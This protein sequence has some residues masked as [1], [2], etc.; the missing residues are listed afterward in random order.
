MFG[1]QFLL[2][3][4]D[5]DRTDFFLIFGANPV[6]SQ[7]SAMT[8]PGMKS[9]LKALRARGGR[10]VVVDPRRT[11]T[12]ALADTHLFIRPGT[13]GLLVAAMLRRVLDRECPTDLAPL[14][15]A[16]APFT[17]EAVARPTGVDAATINAL[18]DDFA[19]AEHAVAYG[20][21]GVSV[22]EFGTTTTWLIEALNHATGNLDAIGGAMFGRPAV[23]LAG[24]ARYS[25]QQGGFGPETEAGL[26]VFAGERPVSGLAG[27]IESGA[28]R[29]FVTQAGNP[30]LS[31]PG[32]RR[33]DAAFKK[34]EYFVAFDPRINETTR[35]AHLI[36]PPPR[37]L[38]RDWYG[39][40]FNALALRDVARYNPPV[41]EPDAHR[42]DCFELLTGVTLAALRHR[43]AS[44]LPARA[45]V[46]TARRLGPRRM[47]DLLLRLGPHRLSLT[48]LAAAPRGLDLGAR[49]AG[50][51]RKP[52]AMCHPRLMADLD[53]L[54][55]SLAAEPPPLVLIG[56]RTLR[57]MNSWLNDSPRMVKGKNRCTARMHPT[58]ATAR[59]LTDGQTI[60]ITG[61]GGR[62]E[63]PLEVSDE[64]MPGVVSVPHGWGHGRAGT[65]Q[66]VA[67]AHPGASYN[68]AI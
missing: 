39:L 68:D 47:L 13:D 64:V 51:L 3:V 29:G 45:A 26:P 41:I 42:P 60:A 23:D 19:A 65:R 27:A 61:D 46:A 53:R 21:M 50:R 36:L 59:G 38:A 9:R 66:P 20:R 2:P 58:D 1:H 56:R 37:P 18:A 55:A 67:S 24:F 5:V 49:T 15:A 25:G 31:L 52:P 57:S 6:V 62:I 7:G 28:L 48:K 63:V 17:A 14:K 22:V 43:G 34:L 8:A 30:V 4:P 10:L 33:L 35:H 12:A 44:A 32:G 40:I 54:A 16:L 11:E